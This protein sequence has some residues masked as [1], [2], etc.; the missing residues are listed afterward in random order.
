MAMV[1]YEVFADILQKAQ[2]DEFYGVICNPLS[3]SIHHFLL[4]EA[5]SLSPY[6]LRCPSCRHPRVHSITTESSNAIVEHVRKNYMMGREE[7]RRVEL[8]GARREG[9]RVEEKGGGGGGG[10]ERK[11][12]FSDYNG[13]PFFE[14]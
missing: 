9:E 14:R 2:F 3:F 13:L 12:H 8:S 7:N 11:I 4:G 5:K 1:I 6:V 10:A